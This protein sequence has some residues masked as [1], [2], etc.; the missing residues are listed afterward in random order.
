MLRKSMAQA[1]VILAPILGIRQPSL[2]EER[3]ISRVSGRRVRI[4]LHR[5]TSLAWGS[6]IYVEA[7]KDQLRTSCSQLFPLFEMT[8]RAVYVAPV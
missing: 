2:V 8:W 7:K 6:E 3:T 4:L 5:L 1:G